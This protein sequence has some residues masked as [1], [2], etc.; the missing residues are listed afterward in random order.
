M[1]KLV[2]SVEHPGDYEC[3]G[4]TEHFPAE[5]ESPKEFLAD[6]ETQVNGWCERVREYHKEMRS[7]EKARPRSDSETERFKAW[8][9]EQPELPATAG[10]VKMGE[11]R[12]S[13]HLFVQYDK[14]EK[15]RYKPPVV[16]TLAEWFED[17]G[18]E[19]KRS[20]YGC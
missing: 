6:L 9:Q 10:E 13:V 2:V 5:H 15:Q 20:V 7:W 14:K 3:G 11:Y 17:C 16:R 8:R 12:F 19:G 4:H 18:V 1:Q